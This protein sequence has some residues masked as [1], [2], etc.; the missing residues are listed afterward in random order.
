MQIHPNTAFH[1]TAAVAAQQLNQSH[2]SPFCK[3]AKNITLE[4]VRALQLTC[5]DQMGSLI[6]VWRF[7]SHRQAQIHH[8]SSA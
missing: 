6:N 8:R 7:T 5:G 3:R 4:D 1:I 2:L